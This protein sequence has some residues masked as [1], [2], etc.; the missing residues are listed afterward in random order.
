MTDRPRVPRSGWLALGAV[1]GAL[2]VGAGGQP[3]KI[4]TLVACLVVIGSIAVRSFARN[5]S[6]ARAAA[7]GALPLAIGALLI[8]GRGSLVGAPA[9][10]STGATG[11]SPAALDPG[12]DPAGR[13]VAIVESVGSPKAAEQIALIR[14]QVGPDGCRPGPADRGP[15]APLPRDRRGRPDRRPWPGPG[16]GRRRLRCLSP[17]D[18]GG[19]LAPLT[20]ARSSGRSG[21]CRRACSIASGGGPLR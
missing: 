12:L 10:I 4:T 17:A 11:S 13:H 1:A 21:G 9:Q 18:R 14:L 8:L 6:R 19:R 7:R 15:P 2:A 5:R 20:D 16:T 3:V